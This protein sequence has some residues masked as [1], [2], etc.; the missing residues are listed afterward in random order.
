MIHR[1]VITTICIL[2]ILSGFGQKNKSI[3]GLR[4]GDWTLKF[5]TEHGKITESGEYKIIPISTYDTIRD[6][7]K[8]YYEVR[9]KKATPLLIYNRISQGNIDVKDGIW[10]TLDSA[11]RL[12][13]I[14]FWENGLNTWTKWFDASGNLDRY[15]YDDYENDT[16]FYLTYIN[17]QLFKKEWYPPEDKNNRGVIYYPNNSLFISDAEPYFKTNFLNKRSDTQ[18]IQLSSAK[19][20][21]IA[22]ITVKN[23][24]IKISGSGK[25]LFFPLVIRPGDKVELALISNPESRTY[26]PADTILIKSSDTP[27]LYKI[28]CDLFASHVTYQNVEKLEELRLSR[29]KDRYLIIPSLG[30]V[31]DATIIAPSGGKRVYDIPELTKIDL[32]D[33]T[34]GS[35]NLEISSCN[36][37]GS[38]KLVITE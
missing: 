8:Y 16:S 30:S 24:T 21:E 31:T 33:Y 2:L 27:E 20:L 11:G 17:K 35:Y 38:I 34:A 18:Y 13:Q 6:L 12:F 14:D 28:Y 1:I 32:L 22:S 3:G 19:E 9:Y 26:L 7:G 23:K 37:G 36:T 10:E 25:N 5:I 15:D 4:T 29:T